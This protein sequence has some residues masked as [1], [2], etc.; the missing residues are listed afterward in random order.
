[1][2]L[3]LVKAAKNIMYDYGE[4]RDVT[5]AEAIL[6]TILPL[7]APFYGEPEIANR[8]VDA[9]F[10]LCVDMKNSGNMKRTRDIYK[11]VKDLE[12][13]GES[14]ARLEKLKTAYGNG[15]IS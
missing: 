12:V 8:V 10:N 5:R 9:A 14:A 2:V 15:Q 4:A 13:E 1:V 11:Q 7:A 3:R 6:N